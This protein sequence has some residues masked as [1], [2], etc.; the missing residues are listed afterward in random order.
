MEIWPSAHGASLPGHAPDQPVK[1]NTH[2]RQDPVRRIGSWSTT[3]LLADA[4]EQI[5]YERAFREYLESFPAGDDGVAR[6][7]T[8]DVRYADELGDG[9]I[10]LIDE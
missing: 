7:T 2:R 5:F 3:K 8:D 1:G 10:T 9:R 4:G 6:V